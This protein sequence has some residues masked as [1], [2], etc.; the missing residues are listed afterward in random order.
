MRFK[1]L[2]ITIAVV[3]LLLLLYIIFH[4]AVFNR[5]PIAG[6]GFI[7]ILGAFWLGRRIAV[8]II[9]LTP[10]E[11]AAKANKEIHTAR[12]NDRDQF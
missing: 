4:V 2:S 11:V 5:P 10:E 8:R 7:V 1:R 3:F 6:G 9:P 12:F